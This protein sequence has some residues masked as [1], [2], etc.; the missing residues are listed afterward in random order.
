MTS[1]IVFVAL[2]CKALGVGVH[3]MNKQHFLPSSTSL[4]VAA[5]PVE[6]GHAAL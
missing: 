4:M 2:K 3:P 5:E 6:G 1:V